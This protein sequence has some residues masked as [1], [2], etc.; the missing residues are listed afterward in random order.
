MR[1]IN[2]TLKR[3]FDIVA[4]GIAIIILLPVWLGVSVA[5]KRDSKGPVFF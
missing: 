3:V 4:S 5:I 1:N 2:L